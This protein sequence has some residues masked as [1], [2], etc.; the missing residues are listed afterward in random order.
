[1]LGC[2]GL[3][4]VFLSFFLVCYHLQPVNK[5]LEIVTPHSTVVSLLRWPVVAYP[6]CRY[7]HGNLSCRVLQARCTSR[8]QWSWSIRLRDPDLRL[9]LIYGIS[10]ALLVAASTLRRSH[11]DYEPKAQRA[12]LP[13]TKWPVRPQIGTFLG[14]HCSARKLRHVISTT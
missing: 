6:C 5:G 2:V 4:V 1:V 10:I 3:C 13:K 12:T 8:S 11:S 9:I 7:K 14:Y